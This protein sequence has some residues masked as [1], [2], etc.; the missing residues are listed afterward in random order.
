MKNLNNTLGRHLYMILPVLIGIAIFIISIKIMI[1]MIFQTIDKY[2]NLKTATDKLTAVTN[3]RITLESIASDN[4]TT[5][6]NDAVLALPNE[7]NADTILTALENISNKT[8]FL[9]DNISFNPGQISSVSAAIAQVA[10]QPIPAETSNTSAQVLSVSTKAHG[11]LSNFPNFLSLLLNSRRIFN[12]KSINIEFSEDKNTM[13]TDMVVTAYYLPPPISISAPETD[14][15]K[16][17]TAEK[18]TLDKLSQL[19]LTTE[20]AQA[21]QSGLVQIGKSNLFSW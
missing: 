11:L 9:L 2:N 12:L 7:K 15:P 5:Y 1:P 13:S 21:S 10:A 18:Q 14:L 4:T 16:I 3:K 20:V 19:P 6:L 8:Q 17:T